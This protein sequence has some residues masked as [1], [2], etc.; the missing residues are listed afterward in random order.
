MRVKSELNAFK[1]L[2][3][4]SQK[5]FSAGLEGHTSV[6]CLCVHFSGLNILL[7]PKELEERSKKKKKPYN[8]QEMYILHVARRKC[9]E[10]K[11]NA[12]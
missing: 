10:R 6:T 9:Q 5:E 4:G 2:L 1:T 8:S 3:V 11:I 12:F 7:L